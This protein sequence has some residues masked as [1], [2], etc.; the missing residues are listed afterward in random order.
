MKAKNKNSIN[1]N[2]K[3][4]GLKMKTKRM[5]TLLAIMLVGVLVNAQSGGS[6]IKSA[7]DQIQLDNLKI[8]V[9]GYGAD[10]FDFFSVLSIDQ[11]D[12]VRT[13]FDKC[14]SGSDDSRVCANAIKQGAKHHPY[15]PKQPDVDVKNP[16]A[17]TY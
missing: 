12:A 4:G 14:K 9:M 3:T 15:F 6:D 1:S 10:L 17:K 8:M 5:I 11:E 13:T 7:H 16:I 2:L